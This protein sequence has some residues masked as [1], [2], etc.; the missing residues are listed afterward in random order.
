MRMWLGVCGITMIEYF[1]RDSTRDQFYNSHFVQLPDLLHYIC[2]CTLQFP[3][4]NNDCIEESSNTSKDFGT[5]WLGVR[6]V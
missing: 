3:A 5:S 1:M 6:K 2:S 4:P